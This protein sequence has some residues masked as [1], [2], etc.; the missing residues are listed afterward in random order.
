[1]LRDLIP[2]DQMTFVERR[3]RE[4]EIGKIITI[5]VESWI[6]IGEGG[7]VIEEQG[8]GEETVKILI[9]GEVD[10]PIIERMIAI[11]GGREID[12][13]IQIMARLDGRKDIGDE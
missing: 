8:I 5:E 2:R 13:I 4:E 9:L 12:R 10:I 1:M 3:G 7:N 11:V 6:E